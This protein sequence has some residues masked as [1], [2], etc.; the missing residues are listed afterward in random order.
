MKLMKF[1]VQV[2]DAYACEEPQSTHMVIQFLKFYKSVIFNWSRP[3]SF[4]I[5]FSGLSHFPSLHVTNISV[6]QLKGS[7][8]K[9]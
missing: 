7:Q 9:G 8:G 6:I 5:L 3:I 1:Q 4:S 2:S